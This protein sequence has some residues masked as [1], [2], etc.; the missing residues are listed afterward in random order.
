MSK[1]EKKDKQQQNNEDKTQGSKGLI[2]T[3]F[4]EDTI[5][6]NPEDIIEKDPDEERRNAFKK[7]YEV[8]LALFPETIRKKNKKSKEKEE[9]DRNLAVQQKDRANIEKKQK[10][11]EQKQK[12]IGE[13]KNNG[14]ERE[15]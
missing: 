11:I 15:D 3:I 6:E 10:E 5:I 9:F 8:I 13:R 12:E 2:E 4:S 1:V 7:A 14:F